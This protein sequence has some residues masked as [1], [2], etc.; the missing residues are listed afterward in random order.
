MIELGMHDVY[1]IYITSLAKLMPGLEVADDE[2]A[3]RRDS[4]FVD[5]VD[6]GQKLP[7][8]PFSGDAATPDSLEELE[9]HK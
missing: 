9:Q 1:V 7:G 6:N 2:V 4:P 5:L 8:S 3:V